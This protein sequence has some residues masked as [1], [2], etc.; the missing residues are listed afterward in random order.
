MVVRSIQSLS[1]AVD[2]SGGTL[3]LTTH[4]NIMKKITVDDFVKKLNFTG[5]HC[6]YCGGKFIPDRRGH[7]GSCGAPESI[8]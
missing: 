7:C 5:L 6:S 8:K 2:I 4:D 3:L 1:T